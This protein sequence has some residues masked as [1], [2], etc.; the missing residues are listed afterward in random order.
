MQPAIYLEGKTIRSND[1]SGQCST[2]TTEIGDK[3]WRDFAGKIPK[4]EREMASR[5]QGAIV[6]YV[7]HDYV[8]EP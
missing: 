1:E 2:E 6:L 3:C 7:R 5:R 8:D 4:E